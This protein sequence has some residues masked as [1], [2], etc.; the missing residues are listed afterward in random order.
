MSGIGLRDTETVGVY[1]VVDLGDGRVMFQMAVDECGDSGF[2][3]QLL[4]HQHDAEVDFES[5]SR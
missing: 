4:I 2:T 3:Q 1:D 5:R